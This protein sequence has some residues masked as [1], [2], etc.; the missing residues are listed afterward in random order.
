MNASPLRLARSNLLSA[1]PALLALLA[2][3]S[4]QDAQDGTW[5]PVLAFDAAQTC[6]GD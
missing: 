2:C 1:L 6:H 5:H 3:G 4:E